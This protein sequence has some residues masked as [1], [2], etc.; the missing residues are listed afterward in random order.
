MDM[1]KTEPVSIILIAFN[2][3]ATIEREVRAFYRIA[4]KIPGSELIVTED[5]HQAGPGEGEKGIYRGPPGRL[6]AARPRM[7]MFL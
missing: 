2:E 3:A 7:D 4:E 6:E 5:P 1:V